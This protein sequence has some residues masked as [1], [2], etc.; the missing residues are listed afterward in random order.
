MCFLFTDPDLVIDEPELQSANLNMDKKGDTLSEEEASPN[1]QRYEAR[2]F[3][4]LTGHIFGTIPPDFKPVLTIPWT[5]RHDQGI[6]EPAAD[7]TIIERFTTVTQSEQSI[8]TSIPRRLTLGTEIE[9]FT[10]IDGTKFIPPSSTSDVTSP[11]QESENI[12]LEGT[13]TEEPSL[14]TTTTLFA[15]TSYKSSEESS[16]TTAYTTDSSTE[17]PPPSS[18]PA[19]SETPGLS[20][21]TKI[22]IGVVSSKAPPPVFDVFS[23]L[24]EHLPNSPIVQIMENQE[25]SASHET[26]SSSKTHHNDPRELVDLTGSVYSTIPSG[27][28]PVLTLASLYLPGKGREDVTL[29]DKV[30]STSIKDG[31]VVIGTE[32]WEPFTWYTRHKHETFTLVLRPMETTSSDSDILSIISHLMLPGATPTTLSEE[33]TLSSSTSESLVIPTAESSDGPGSSGGWAFVLIMA[34]FVLVLS[35]MVAVVLVLRSRFRHSQ[36]NFNIQ[37]DNAPFGRTYTEPVQPVEPAPAILK[38]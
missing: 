10:I 24:H 37:L 3:K 5:E 26:D 1:R 11:S 23:S 6:S 30:D 20:D 13:T 8:T 38:S 4:D 28:K 31:V 17:L 2:D 36:N 34:G 32:T 27:F 14:S 7:L 29:I 18:S 35:A 9:I 15:S 25:I 22:A 12:S 19:A 16:W 21:T 33:L